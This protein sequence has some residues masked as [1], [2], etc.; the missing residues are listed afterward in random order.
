MIKLLLETK[1]F[2]DRFDGASL[3]FMATAV[4]WQNSAATIEHDPNVA[5]LGRLEC[6]AQL[7][8]PAFEFCT[9]QLVNISV[10]L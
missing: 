10:Y 9:R 3:Q 8:Q 1:L 7:F 2:L 5:A 4:H 6:C